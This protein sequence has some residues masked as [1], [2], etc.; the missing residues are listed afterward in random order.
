MTGQVYFK[1]HL[2][3]AMFN[4]AGVISGQTIQLLGILTEHV[5][6]PHLQDRYLA[7]ENRKY[8]MNNARHLDGEEITYRKGGIYG[9]ES[10]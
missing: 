5:H 3:D 2:M 9:E 6:T 8:I 4:L 7:I 10:K 1:G